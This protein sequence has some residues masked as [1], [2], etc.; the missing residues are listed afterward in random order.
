MGL[1]S[2]SNQRPA[3]AVVP[4]ESLAFAGGL[5]AFSILAATHRGDSFS[6]GLKRAGFRF[7][8]KGRLGS[9]WENPSDVGGWVMS[10]TE[11]GGPPA[12]PRFGFEISATPTLAGGPSEPLLRYLI[13]Y[14][15]FHS[16]S[17]DAA[18]LSWSL[19]RSFCL[20]DD[21]AFPSRTFETSKSRVLLGQI[22]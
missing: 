8:L 12:T 20:R 7:R 19:L 1:P 21:L 4:N 11:A 5:A 16:F 10:P 3:D 17:S 15:R 9:L 2:P 22:G 18:Y 13:S 6:A 14:F